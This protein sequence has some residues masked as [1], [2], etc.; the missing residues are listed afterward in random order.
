MNECR[1]ATTQDIAVGLTSTLDSVEGHTST[2]DSV[3]ASA[4]TQAKTG[5]S[6]YK[7]K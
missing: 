5:Y 3:E 7:P 6:F 4:L 2:L 1:H